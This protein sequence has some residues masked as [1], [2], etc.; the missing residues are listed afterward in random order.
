MTPEK[1]CIADDRSPVYTAMAGNVAPIPDDRV[2]AHVAERTD[3]HVIA[4]RN[5]GV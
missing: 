1:Y 4:N 3:S 5:V 2:V